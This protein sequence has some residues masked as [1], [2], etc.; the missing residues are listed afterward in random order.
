[1]PVA[2]SGKRKREGGGK[3][4]VEEDSRRQTSALLEFNLRAD[5]TG[6]AGTIVS[7]NCPRSL[8]LRKLSVNRADDR[9]GTPSEYKESIPRVARGVDR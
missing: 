9:R 8:R 3:G 7:A 6:S 2:R 4:C 1:M 5:S